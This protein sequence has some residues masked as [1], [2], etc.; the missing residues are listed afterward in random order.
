MSIAASS[1]ES[2]RQ[3]ASTDGVWQQKL[4]AREKY[5]GFEMGG[6]RVSEN[7]DYSWQIVRVPQLTKRL[8]LG[9]DR[10]RQHVADIDI[11]FVR[12]SP[13]KHAIGK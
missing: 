11:P 6:E 2:A 1:A 13:C 7:C 8:K 10:S 3:A 4:R 9:L 5:D 12:T